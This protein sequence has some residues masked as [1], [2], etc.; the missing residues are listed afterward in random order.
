MSLRTTASTAR[1]T[2]TGHAKQTNTAR[3]HAV[4]RAG[5]RYGYKDDSGV[6][7]VEFVPDDPKSASIARNC[8]R[9]PWKNG[10]YDKNVTPLGAFLSDV[11]ADPRLKGIGLGAPFD[12]AVSTTQNPAVQS[13]ADTEYSLMLTK[14]FPSGSGGMWVMDFVSEYDEFARY[15][16]V[17]VNIR[18]VQERLK[19]AIEHVNTVLSDEA[20]GRYGLDTSHEVTVRSYYVGAWTRALDTLKNM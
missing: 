14:P 7:Y 12:N 15:C 3:L 6:K 5:L 18:T 19:K 2:G 16:L 11:T 10:V 8:I 13:H 17:P 9:V 4:L 20:L 1:G